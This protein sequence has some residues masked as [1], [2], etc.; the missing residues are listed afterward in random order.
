MFNIINGQNRNKTIFILANLLSVQY[1]TCVP[2][3][4]GGMC[5]KR[6]STK[7]SVEI[8]FSLWDIQS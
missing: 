4:G 7:K 1:A 6:V 8:W 3:Q 2:C 5:G